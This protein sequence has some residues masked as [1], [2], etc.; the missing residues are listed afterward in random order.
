MAAFVFNI[1]NKLNQ[2]LV[3]FTL[4]LILTLFSSTA[5]Y[6]DLIIG[7]TAKST[8]RLGNFTGEF[9][10]H[11]DTSTKAELNVR[12]TNTSPADNGGYL[13]GFVFNNP[14]NYITGVTLTGSNSNF[15]LLGAPSFKDS[16]NA[17]PFGNFDIGAALGGDFL[18]GGSPK[19]G[20]PAGGSANFYFAIT[21]SNLDKLNAGSFLGATNS[22]G[23]FSAARFRG[24]ENGG[25]DKV[26][27]SPN[28]VPIPPTVYLL[29]AGLFGVG[30]IRKRV[31]KS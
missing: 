31:R 16:I 4:F 19:N 17:A 22:N 24:F 27:A 20:I 13:T 15:K 6:A 8:E 5:L 30:F 7:N 29:G 9:T 3:L 23:D 11:Y 25:S 21:G 10:Y 2:S 28:P 26:P 12:L 1:K 18:G 14:N